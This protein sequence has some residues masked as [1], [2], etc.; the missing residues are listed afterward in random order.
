MFNFEVS[1][2][3]FLKATPLARR[4]IELFAQSGSEV[5][6]H[7]IVELASNVQILHDRRMGRL[8]TIHF[9]IDNS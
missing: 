9:W 2:E 1:V 6:F 4:W 7:P 8:K 5:P 3:S